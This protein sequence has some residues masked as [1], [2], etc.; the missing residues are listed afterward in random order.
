MS[1]SIWVLS[2]FSAPISAQVQLPFLPGLLLQ[3]APQGGSAEAGE[4]DRVLERPFPQP[5]PGEDGFLNRV[6]AWR[7]R[8][9]YPAFEKVGL[10]SAQVL[11]I[12]GDLNRSA[13]VVLFSLRPPAGSSLSSG[14]PA[15]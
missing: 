3:S 9:T 13:L 2:V 15:P 5:G 7:N 4:A 14:F 1:D 6:R 8:L 10:T 12:K 11:K